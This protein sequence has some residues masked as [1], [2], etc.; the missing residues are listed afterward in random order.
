GT[1]SSTAVDPIGPLGE[2]AKMYGVWVH[3]DAV[4]AG[5]AFIFQEFGY[6]IDGVEEADSFI[7]NAHKWFFT[8]LDCYCLLVK[9]SD[10]FAKAL[11]K[12]P[13][14]LKNKAIE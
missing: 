14:Y 10:S 6:F 3:V 11:P 7:L 13:E 5:S 9:D 1:P 12:N 2:V 4:Y 8:A